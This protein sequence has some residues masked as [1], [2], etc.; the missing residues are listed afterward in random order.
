TYLARQR[1]PFASAALGTV[2]VVPSGSR[3]VFVQRSSTPLL[4]LRLCIIGVPVVLEDKVF[5]PPVHCAP[6][7]Q[8]PVDN[9]F[10]YQYFV[11]HG[12]Y[13]RLLYRAVVVVVVDREV[14]ALYVSK[15]IPQL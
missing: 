3:T 5:H 7:S 12:V 15:E 10:T 6:I 9:A 8:K 1:K 4:R 2:L 11:H 13:N 14:V